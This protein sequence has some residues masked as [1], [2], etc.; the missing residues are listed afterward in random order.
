MAAI[1]D[2]PAPPFPAL[3]LPPPSEA[4]AFAQAVFDTV[5][6]HRRL[7][8]VRDVYSPAAH[9]QQP[10]GRLLFG[11]GEIAGWATALLATFSDAR[12]RIDHVASVDGEAGRDIAVRWEMAGTHDGAGLYGPSTGEEAYVLAV[13][14]W[15]VRDGVIVD[16]VTVFDEIALLRQLEGGL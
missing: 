5:W 6:N 3:T 12:F 11:H 13:T 9:S 1:R 7:T 4:E 14:H 8:L 10:G 16:E 2:E 15:R